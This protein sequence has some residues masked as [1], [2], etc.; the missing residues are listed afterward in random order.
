MV[1]LTGL[2]VASL[3]GALASAGAGIA[4]S[5]INYN[6]QKETN[7]Q[8][9]AMQRETNAQALMMSNTAHQ[10]EML[11][12]KN[13][14]LNPVLTATGGNGSPVAAISSPKAQAPQFDMS[15]IGSAIQG[16]V[17]SLT[18]LKM[19][20]MIGDRYKELSADKIAADA[21][22]KGSKTEYYHAMAN[23]LRMASNGASQAALFS[24]RQASRHSQYDGKTKEE[25]K[26]IWEEL[27]GE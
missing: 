6:L 18:N 3:V 25:L 1:T 5:A 2:L 22:L 14:G 27:L 21:S 17:Q 7:A 10:R 20:E 19:A 16:T 24:P 15:S 8:N 12:L 23:R 4:G 26:K 13:A 9:I 11:D